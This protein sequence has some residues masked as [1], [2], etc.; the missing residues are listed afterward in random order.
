VRPR[1][2]DQSAYD[3]SA[4]SCRELQQEGVQFIRDAFS[5]VSRNRQLT[6][7]FLRADFADVSELSGKK[8][9]LSSENRHFVSFVRTLLEIAVY[10]PVILG[11]FF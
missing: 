2:T 1:G 4:T 6:V 3:V 7:Q 9:L 8:S 11:A 5:E 10:R